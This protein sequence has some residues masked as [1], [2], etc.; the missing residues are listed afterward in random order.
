MIKKYLIIAVVAL[1]LLYANDL[2]LVS[3]LRSST[4]FGAA[5]VHPYQEAFPA[6]F[7]GGS[8]E[9]QIVNSS[10]EWTGAINGASGYNTTILGNLTAG[11]AAKTSQ[12]LIRGRLKLDERPTGGSTEDYALQIRG[13][14]GKTSGTYWGIDNESHLKA[15]GTASV[16][17][18]QGVAVLDSTYTNTGGSLVGTYGQARS[19]GTFNN[20]AGF[21]TGLYGVIEASAAMTASH[22]ASAWLDSH[23]NNAVTG[24]HELL[25]MT[26]NGSATM[27][28]AFYVYGG[29]KIASLFNLNTVGGGL[30]TK[31]GTDA[32]GT[33]VKVHVVIDGTDYWLNAYPTS[34]N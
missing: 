20:A 25:Y 34:N 32:S 10:G 18:T 7:V 21:V 9:H 15:N 23:Q 8:D 12:N 31:T 33:A 6:G 30:V 13:E 17:G 24:E 3:G 28:Q 4:P 1:A 26:N 22:V 16:R 14:S 2:L 5:T 11:N 27:D 29:N 19:D